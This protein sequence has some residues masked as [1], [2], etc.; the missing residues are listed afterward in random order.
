VSG[1][2][3]AALAVLLAAAF[4]AGVIYIFGVQFASGELYPE[5]SSLRADADGVKLLF[6]S[7]ARLPGVTTARNY[8]PL[9][10]LPD[11]DATV[12]LLNM[13]S[14]TLS[15]DS[16][17]FLLMIQKLAERGNRVV[18]SLREYPKPDGAKLVELDEKWHVRLGIDLK[19][20]AAHPL[21]FSEAKGWD[22]FEHE[23][24]KLLAIERHFGKGSVALISDSGDFSNESTAAADRLDVVTA[25]IGGNS[26]IVFDESHLGIAE[27][28]SVVGLARR[29]RL[30]G[31]ATGLAICAALFVWRSASAFPAGAPA[32][33]SSAPPGRTSHAGLL[34]L[35]RRHIPPAELTGACWREYL[36]ANRHSLTP[37]RLSQ[38]ETIARSMSNRPLD[39]VREISAALHSKSSGHSKGSL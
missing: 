25:A 23:G 17:R 37:E 18:L 30:M 9:E 3:Q 13:E 6:E 8:L 2:K 22:V 20:H 31:F 33:A 38:A 26:R 7:L 32:Q 21:F 11:T 35:L 15:D 29:F 39:A 16:T 28:G 4:G 12:L 10:I 27:S 14:E 34:T 36:V 5:Y 1:W 24:L 19:K